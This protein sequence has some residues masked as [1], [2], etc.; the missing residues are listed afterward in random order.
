[1]TRLNPPTQN[2]SL[3]PPLINTISLYGQVSDSFAVFNDQLFHTRTCLKDRISTDPVFPEIFSVDR[4]RSTGHNWVHQADLQS[5]TGRSPNHVAVDE[6]VI[7][8]DSEQYW[9]YA[10]VD[11][12]SNDLPHTKREPTKILLSQI[13]FLMNSV[14]NTTQMTQ[15]SR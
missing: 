7:Q 14:K 11:P 13:Y 1:M 2:R 9:L 3:S 15:F 4:V 10:A 12:E 8:L 6:T 5:E